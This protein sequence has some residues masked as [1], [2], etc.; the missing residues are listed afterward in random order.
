MTNMVVHKLGTKESK[1]KVR[2]L[3][4]ELSAT[5]TQIDGWV[6]VVVSALTFGD[7]SAYTLLQDVSWVYA[8]LGDVHQ[9]ENN[10]D[11][12]TEEHVLQ[13]LK[14]LNDARNFPVP[15]KNVLRVILKA[16][17]TE[18]LCSIQALELL[19]LVKSWFK[20]NDLQPIM[21]E[22]NV[23]YQMGSVI[24]KNSSE[25][26]GHSMEAYILLGAML[27]SLSQWA[28]YIHCSPSHWITIYYKN[29]VHQSR[30]LAPYLSVLERIWGVKYTGTLHPMKDLEKTLA[31]TQ[32]AL[33]IVWENFDFSGQQ[34][35]QDFY[36]LI[37]CTISTTFKSHNP[38]GQYH[39]VI[40]PEFRAAFYSPLGDSLIQAARKADDVISQTP[41]QMD[42][43]PD[44]DG[45]IQE[46]TE[47]EGLHWASRILDEMGF[48]LKHKSEG[49][50][51]DHGR[52]GAWK[53]WNNLRAHF[54]QQ[55]DQLE[56]S[57]K[58]SPGTVAI[59]Y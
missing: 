35:L 1:K 2:Q 6:D 42:N 36:P 24:M 34:T 17:S 11:V 21:Q 4:Y 48:A 29:P 28:P 59:S 40:S 55:V 47:T 52:E 3:V 18:S 5:I 49:E 12:A 26:S 16:L 32:I 46:E 37:R 7:L 20:D 51:V 22:H 44:L 56:E 23:W 43:Q 8:A 50:Q 15:S 45:S 9:S 31:W 58:E 38:Y 39:P 30:L 14:A 19:C 27:S 57:V 53:Y 10:W 25:I 33:S 13:L 54:E 41:T